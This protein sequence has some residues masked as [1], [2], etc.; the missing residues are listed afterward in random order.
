LSWQQHIGNKKHRDDLAKRARNPDDPLKLVL[1]RDMWLTG[2]DAPCMNTMYIDKP[3]R[4][5]GLMQAIARVNRVFKDKPGGLIVDYIGIAAN[6]KNALADYSNTDRDQ[7]GI[8]EEAAVAKLRELV[9]RVQ[10]IFH[11]FNYQ[12]GLAGPPLQRLGAIDWVLKWQEVEALKA[13]GIDKKKQSHRAFQDIIV[14]LTKG[15]ALSS[16]SDY[17]RNVQDEVGFFQ[18]VKASIA[19]TTATGKMSSA[20][21][22]FAVQQLID[23]AIADSEIVDILKAAGINSP[24]I[25]VLSDEFLAEIKGMDKKNL[26]LEALKKLLNGEIKSR[27]KSNLVESRAFSRRLEEAVARYHTN[28]ITALEMIN[29]LI[30]LAK[31]LQAAQNRGEEIGLSPEEIAFYDALAEN[32]SALKAMGNDKLRVIAQELV[33]HLKANATV[34]W[35]KRESA[36]AKMRVLVKRILKKYGYPPDLADE[37][38]QTVLAQAEILLSELV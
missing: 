9:E 2:F 7:T 23:R 26:A 32:E 29:E 24:N 3:M 35:Q 28:A 4:G 20:D 14:E 12:S 36:R 27:S 31:D 19:K 18:A 38:V 37:A 33:D 22:S 5:H 8:D 11:G 16:A 13:T 17:A 15:Y 6:L 1:V 34:D 21:R 25:S 10:S 30:A